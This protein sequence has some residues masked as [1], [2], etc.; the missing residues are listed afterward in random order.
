[1]KVTVNCLRLGLAWSS[2]CLQIWISCMQIA[3]ALHQHFSFAGQKANK[4]HQ[5][6]GRV[7]GNIWYSNRPNDQACRN[8]YADV[9]VSTSEPYVLQTAVSSLQ[10][11]QRKSCYLT[12]CGRFRVCQAQQIA[13]KYIDNEFTSKNN[14]PEPLFP[15]VYFFLLLLSL[16]SA[17]RWPRC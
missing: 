10:T 16:T 14:L 15:A 13:I 17:C 5:G 8:M 7:W 3:D 2:T 9:F 6:D 12:I 11:Q 4:N 1:M